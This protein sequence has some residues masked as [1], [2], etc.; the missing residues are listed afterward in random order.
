MT[1]IRVKPRGKRLFRWPAFPSLVLLTGLVGI[2]LLM[3]MQLFHSTSTTSNHNDI[4]RAFP[5]ADGVPSSTTQ[6]RLLPLLPDDPM[7]PLDHTTHEPLNVTAFREWAAKPLVGSYMA[8][9]NTRIHMPFIDLQ[10]IY[11]SQI[12]EL[13][14]L[15]AS[16]ANP[17]CVVLTRKGNKFHISGVAANQDR[18]AILDRPDEFWMGLFDG[19]GDLGHVVS[20]AALA[21]F[22]KMLEKIRIQVLTPEETKQ[23]LHTMVLSINENL[24]N[25]MG[26]GSTAISIWR[27]RNQLFISNV[28]DSKAFVVSV[29]RTHQRQVQVLYTTQPHKPDDP[30]ERKRIESMGGEV[31]EA[32]DPKFSARVLIPF[33]DPPHDYMGLAMSRSLGDFDGHPYGVIADPTTDVID[34]AALDPQLDYLVI[35]ASDGL[36]DRVSQLEIGKL[37]AESQLLTPTGK[38]LSLEAAEQLI[39]QSSLSWRNDVFGDGYRDDISLAVHRLRI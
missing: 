16:F 25:I 22:P 3:S 18:I 38:Y 39:L 9:R 19:H 4:T 28:G 7:P 15:K 31:Q 30:L 17:D 2:L 11:K 23:A 10:S 32:P 12:P 26:A 6:L 27:R 24:P 29:D 33:G 13:P 8:S 36:L 14:V 1:Q 34:L 5:A 35:L 20:H 37:M 21:E